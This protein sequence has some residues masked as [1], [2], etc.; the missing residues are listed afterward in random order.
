MTNN[1]AILLSEMTSFKAT[2]PLK[3]HATVIASLRVFLVCP[4]AM[5]YFHYHVTRYLNKTTSKGGE[6][7]FTTS[8]TPEAVDYKY[9][10]YCKCTCFSGSFILA[11]L[12]LF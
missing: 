12:A 7:L 8:Q 2:I 10:S 9:L 4:K 5:L 3:K 1:I 6:F 11:L